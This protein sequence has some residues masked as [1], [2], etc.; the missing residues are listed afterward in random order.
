MT[1]AAVAAIAASYKWLQG[2][3]QHEQQVA[4]G[5]EVPRKKAPPTKL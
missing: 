2:W 4:L 5:N 3:Q 1:A